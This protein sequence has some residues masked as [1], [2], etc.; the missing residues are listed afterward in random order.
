MWCVH[1]H[2]HSTTRRPK[3]LSGATPQS[4][5]SFRCPPIFESSS[6][7]VVERTTKETSIGK[8]NWCLVRKCRNIFHSQ[9]GRRY[10]PHLQRP[11]RTCVCGS[12]SETQP[13]QPQTAL[14]YWRISAAMCQPIQLGSARPHF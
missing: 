1:W 8:C 9:K 2:F 7:E 4:S 13:P 12:N 10:R 6:L 14:L 5:G 11:Y 3:G